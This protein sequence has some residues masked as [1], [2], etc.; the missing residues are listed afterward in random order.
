[1]SESELGCS[2]LSPS[3]WGACSCLFSYG[4]RLTQRFAFAGSRVRRAVLVVVG[5]R[6]HLL[7]ALALQPW[8]VSGPL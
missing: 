3:V 6:V 1:M 8:T 7:S 5:A 2:C 4:E